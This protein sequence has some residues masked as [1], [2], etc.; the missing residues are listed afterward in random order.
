[1]HI[2]GS[3]QIIK[4]NSLSRIYEKG[5]IKVTA[6]LEVSFEAF[7][8]QFIGIAGKSGSGKSTL[9]NLIG[10]LDRPTSGNIFFNGH[11]LTAMNRYD[12]ALHR[13]LSVGMI[14]QS[15]NLVPTLSALDNVILPLV[16]SGVNRKSRAAVLLYFPGFA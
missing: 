15:F 2:P 7:E 3:S 12:L 11:D 5:N 8:G 10:G 6:L 1:M 16:F 9:L 13:R 4:T 14:F